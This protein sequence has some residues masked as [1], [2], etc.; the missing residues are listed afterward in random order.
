MAAISDE[1]FAAAVAR[2]LETDL[3]E[4]DPYE[5]PLAEAPLW[6]RVGAPLARLLAPVL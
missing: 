2:M 4:C 5:T 3:A 1:R 6:I